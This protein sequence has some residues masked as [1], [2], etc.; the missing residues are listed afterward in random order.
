M[1]ITYWTMIFCKPLRKGSFERQGT[2]YITNDRQIYNLYLDI[3]YAE[4]SEDSEPED[5]DGKP[6]WGKPV[7]IEMSY[8]SRAR[9]VDSIEELKVI[10]GVGAEE[11]RLGYWATPGCMCGGISGSKGS[12]R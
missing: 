12:S 4:D 1:P 6:I 8:P 7:T 10:I 3:P 11:T 9:T 2:A 5:E